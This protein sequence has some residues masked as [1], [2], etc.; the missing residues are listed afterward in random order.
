MHDPSTGTPARLLT[1]CLLGGIAGIA[2]Q[3]QQ[4]TAPAL[5]KGFVYII[6]L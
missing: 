3:L 5:Y 4:A 1:P 6:L 2:L